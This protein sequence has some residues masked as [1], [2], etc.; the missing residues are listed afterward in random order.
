[1][2]QKIHL[3]RSSLT[4]LGSLRVKTKLRGKGM[5]SGGLKEPKRVSKVQRGLEKSRKVRASE[6]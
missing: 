4:L 2:C 6:V 5:T 1:M 3:D